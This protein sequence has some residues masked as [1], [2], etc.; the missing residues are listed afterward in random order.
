MSKEERKILDGGE[1]G[2]MCDRVDWKKGKVEHIENSNTEMVSCQI[3]KWVERLGTMGL[4][5]VVAS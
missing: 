5:M 4:T 1:G 3:Q 2:G